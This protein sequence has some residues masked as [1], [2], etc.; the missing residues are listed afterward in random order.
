MKITAYVVEERRF[1]PQPVLSP[2]EI[3]AEAV[4]IDVEEPTPEETLSLAEQLGLHLELDEA[5]LGSGMYGHVEAEGDQLTMVMQAD[6]ASLVEGLASAKGVNIMSAD[7]VVTFRSGAVPAVE[8]VARAAESMA[9]GPDPRVQLVIQIL[10]NAINITSRALDA[11]EAEV[12]RSAQTLLSTAEATRAEVDLEKVLADLS[13]L[14]MRM[15]TLRYRHQTIGRVAEILLKDPRFSLP[16]ELREDLE[17]A[18]NDVLSLRDFASSIDEQLSRLTDST[19]G[20]IGLRQNASARWF[21][22]IATVFMPPTLLGAIWGMNFEN[23]PELDERY[24]YALALILMLLS[25]T[26]PLWFVR[27]MGWLGRS[28]GGG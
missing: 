8:A 6:R 5:D 28:S 27:K 14:Q 21:S 20:F 16:P 19:M 15:V 9:V 4:W 11:A 12:Y 18:A 26:I 25:A 10:T 7:K 3:P 13:R 2:S 17:L 24:A 1:V 23:M 22:I